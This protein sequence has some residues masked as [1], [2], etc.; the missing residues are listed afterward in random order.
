MSFRIVSYFTR[1]T[2]YQNIM[3]NYLMPCLDILKIPNA[4][5]AIEDTG[6][7]ETNA[8]F[9][10]SIIWRAMK[11]WPNDR[12]VWMDADV[13]VRG[14]PTLFEDI[15]SRCDI[16]LYYRQYQDHYG[17]IPANMG[18]VTPK[19]ELNTGVIWF[20][21]TPKMVGFVEEWMDRCAKD[22][23]KNH[24]LHLHEL[25]NER[26]NDNLSF[27]LIP[28]GYAYIAERED[29]KPPAVPLKDPLI[30]Q[31]NA[32]IFGK[33]DLYDNTQLMGEL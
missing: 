18:I 13:F 26:L 3:I 33:K 17:E 7:W 28:R 31:F 11:T 1:N 10:P 25:V 6:S 32:S 19:P 22:E 30:V 4:I 20:N 16:G 12:I 9:Q 2:I 8:C 5:Y 21:N 23:G 29:G 14:Y 15:P 24:R 27:F